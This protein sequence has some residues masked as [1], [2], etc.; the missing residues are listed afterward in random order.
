[1]GVGKLTESC[2]E[3]GSD[4]CVCLCTEKQ[5]GVSGLHG[6][7]EGHPDN[8]GLHSPLGVLQPSHSQLWR[9][10]EGMDLEEQPA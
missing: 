6:T 9:N 8:W 1:M 10:L 3:G 7:C 4:Y 2:S 5:F